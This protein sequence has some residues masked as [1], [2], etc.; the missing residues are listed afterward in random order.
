[1][2]LAVTIVAVIL[3]IVGVVFSQ[4][5]KTESQTSE[6]SQVLSVEEEQ[7]APEQSTPTVG[8]QQVETLPPTKTPTPSPTNIPKPTSSNLSSFQ[9]PNSSIVNSSENSLI[10][11]SSDNSDTITDWYKEKI[12]GEGMSVTSFVTTKTND[13]VLNKLVGADGEREIR[14]EIK[15]DSGSSTVNI[16]VVVTTD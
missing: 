10:L 7:E 13:S 4:T 3:V 15:K 16:S 5:V 14:V 12:K 6:T 9:Y 8:S 1:M 11:E 2:N